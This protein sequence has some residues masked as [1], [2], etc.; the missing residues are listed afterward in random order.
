MADPDPEADPF[1]PE[2]HP[3]FLRQC[4]EGYI[5]EP[6]PLMPDTWPGDLEG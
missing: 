2:E 6:K 5:Y 1:P 3:D 4:D